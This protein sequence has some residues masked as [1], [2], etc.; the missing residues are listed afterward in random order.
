MPLD[1]HEK[2]YLVKKTRYFIDQITVKQA[3]PLETA[4]GSDGEWF[5]PSFL[6]VSNPEEVRLKLKWVRRK[7]D[8]LK[9]GKKNIV[10]TSE[11]VQVKLRGS[12][13]R[14][15]RFRKR[16]K[17]APMTNRSII[18][19]LIR[20]RVL[21]G[22]VLILRTKIPSCKKKYSDGAYTLWM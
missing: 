4:A 11:N 1:M 13:D 9:L 6:T 8:S 21:I 14:P 17:D 19:F 3:S 16:K 18:N 2:C 20:S 22:S 7:K 15:F 10:M 12:K 5:S